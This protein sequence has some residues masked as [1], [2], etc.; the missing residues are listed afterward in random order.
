M[1]AALYNSF[2][3]GGISGYESK[4]R[5]LRLWRT[6]LERDPC[7]PW[8]PQRLGR[9]IRGDSASASASYTLD[10]RQRDLDGLLSHSERLRK[11][12]DLGQ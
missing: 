2:E 3:N 8:A 1:R 5:I 10:L 9:M 12:I 7:Q 4:W 6:A 11:W